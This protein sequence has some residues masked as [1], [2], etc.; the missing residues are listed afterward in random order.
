MADCAAAVTC[1]LPLQSL[2]DVI[3]DSSHFVVTTCAFGKPAHLTAGHRAALRQIPVHV[4]AAW[5]ARA[6]QLGRRH[7]CAPS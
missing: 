6:D 4:Q 1:V 5:A 7:D 3:L 2:C